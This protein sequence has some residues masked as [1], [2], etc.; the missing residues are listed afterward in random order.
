MKKTFNSFKKLIVDSVMESRR[1]NL[2]FISAG[3]AFYMLFSLVP[4]IIILISA[5][6]FLVGQVDL[7]SSL[8][9]FI[10]D[11]LGPQASSLFL[12]MIESGFQ[13]ERGLITTL[14]GVGI[15]LWGANRLVIQ[16]NQAFS[17]ILENGG[18]FEGEGVKGAIKIKL[19]SLVY[20][21]FLVLLIL[22]ALALNLLVPF[23]IN[24]INQIHPLLSDP[25][26]I[27][28]QS[29]AVF[30][31]MML[32]FGFIYRALAKKRFSWGSAFIGSSIASFLFVIINS[33]FSVYMNY[34]SIQSV[35]GAAGS[36]I[37]LLL[38]LYWLSQAFLFGAS[39][40]NTY[41]HIHR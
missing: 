12:S 16:M 36:L 24:L 21:M 5:G 40:S 39:V 30:I 32:L 28:A 27:L 29:A 14:V 13:N 38:W 31:L 35:Y 34:A 22:A 3:L 26:I 23:L 11:V 1:K 20:T 41:H 18:M 2:R 8:L 7:S 15:I 10:E 19:K 33:G 6:D 4:F 25:L 17:V 37:A 9:M